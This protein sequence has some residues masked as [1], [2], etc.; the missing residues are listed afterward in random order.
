MMMRKGQQFRCQ[1]PECAAE[2]EITKGS[3]EGKSS[4]TCCCGGAMKQP[5]SKPVLKRPA[6]DR[7]NVAR[8]FSKTA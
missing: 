7:S 6:K 3:I 2:I 5:Y 1:N 8:H 4:F